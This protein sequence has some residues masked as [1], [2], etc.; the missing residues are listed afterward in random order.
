MLRERMAE[1]EVKT[2]SVDAAVDVRGKA[3][4]GVV[5]DGGQGSIRETEMA[6]TQVAHWT[7]QLQNPST[8]PR[9]CHLC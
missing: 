6:H 5:S 7:G 4:L 2:G 3:G 8:P 9:E 1:V